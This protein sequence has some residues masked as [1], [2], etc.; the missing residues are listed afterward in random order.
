MPVGPPLP[1]RVVALLVL[2]VGV[3]GLCWNEWRAETAHKVLLAALFCAPT[4]TLLGLA[5]LADPRV[6]WS[7][8][9]RRHGMPVAVRAAGITV[10]ILGVAASIWLAFWRYHVG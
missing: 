9:P 7:L 1:P 6:I 2:T 3:L 8:G 4:V 5:G 10:V